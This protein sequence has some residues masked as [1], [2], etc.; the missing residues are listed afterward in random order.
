MQG[1]RRKAKAGERLPRRRQA[2]NPQMKGQSPRPT[3]STDR[4]L[5]PIGSGDCQ[6]ITVLVHT[7]LVHEGVELGKIHQCLAFGL[8]STELCTLHSIDSGLDRR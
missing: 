6:A 5:N 1:D 3:A 4:S 8:A 7:V 2:S